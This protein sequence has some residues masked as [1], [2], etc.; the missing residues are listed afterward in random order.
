[1]KGGTQLSTI[2]SDSIQSTW[3][4]KARQAQ[5]QRVI[6]APLP[7]VLPDKHLM[8]SPPSEVSTANQPL[9]FQLHAMNLWP[10][11]LLGPAFMQGLPCYTLPGLSSLKPWK[12]S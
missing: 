4:S 11:V 12:N 7:A 10:P 2:A 9:H 5:A 1:M 3:Q 6:A 8:A